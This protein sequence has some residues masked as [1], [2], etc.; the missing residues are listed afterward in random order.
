MTLNAMQPDVLVVRHQDAGAVQLLSRK[1]KTAVLLM[2]E[3]VY[4][5]PTQ[6]LL[7]ALTIKK[8]KGR[9]LA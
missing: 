8:E 9:F 1:S 4:E 7:D 5:H 2:Q 6:A 3:M